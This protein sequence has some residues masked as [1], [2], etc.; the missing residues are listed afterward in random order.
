MIERGSRWVGGRIADSKYKSAK[1]RL[2]C[3]AGSRKAWRRVC[4]S[5]WLSRCRD[6][7]A[8]NVEGLGTAE[9][10]VGQL[11]HQMHGGCYRRKHHGAAAAAGVA[12]LGSY[13]AQRRGAPA[14]QRWPSWMYVFASCIQAR[15]L[16]SRP[17]GPGKEEV[18]ARNSEQEG[19]L[20]LMRSG[21]AARRRWQGRQAGTLPARSGAAR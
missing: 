18:D 10:D 2:V 6:V 1:R 12:R 8:Q 16:S 3:K 15:T 17:A 11:L 9:R 20:N 19:L 14:Q 4:I 21:W 7:H 5:L 13:S